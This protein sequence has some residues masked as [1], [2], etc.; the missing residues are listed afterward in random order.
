MMLATLLLALC[1]N[2]A[3]DGSDGP[4]I[5]DFTAPWCGPCREMKPAVALLQRSGYPIKAVDYD[6]SPLVRK[7]N[8]TAVPTFVVVDADGRELD[9]VEG[10][11]PA[12]D[13]AAMYRKAESRSAPPSD[14][15]RARPEADPE[16]TATGRKLPK[17]WETVVRIR[18]DNH[19]SRPNSI[20]YGSGTIIY[21]TPDEAIILTCAHIFRMHG[22]QQ[23][24]PSKFPLKITVELSDGQIRA[25]SRPDASGACQ[26]GVHMLTSEPLEGE[27]IDYDFAGDVGLIRVRTTRRLPATPVVSADWR[28]QRGLDMT[29]VGCSEGNDA[30]AWSTKIT[31][32]QIRGVDGYP[33]YE[34]IECQFAPK[35]GRSGGGL[36]T[37]DGRLAGVCDFA[38]PTNGHGLYATPRTIHKFLDKNQLTVCYAPDAGRSRG[39]MIASDDGPAR[40]RRS[41]VADTIHLQNPSDSRPAKRLTIPSPDDLQVPSLDAPAAR[42][43]NGSD[44]RRKPSW[45]DLEAETNRD[46]RPREVDLTAPP[47][48]GRDRTAS[49]GDPPRARDRADDAPS[50]PRTGS[51]WKPDGGRTSR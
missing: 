43:A 19:L 34:A 15:P 4:I 40:S 38:E 9:R 28:P 29:T 1:A 22:R 13:I 23:Y 6:T 21:S 2:P 37:A 36:Y 18:I 41:N 39:A 35:L 31:N 7:Y 48:V 17:P 10:F 8:V 30:T 42:V 20:E 5:Y 50:K 16:P 3:D 46:D 32:P 44:R 45:S 26:A 47:S 49:P 51:P 33:N 11:R 12:S 25:R 27:A 14:R 24:S